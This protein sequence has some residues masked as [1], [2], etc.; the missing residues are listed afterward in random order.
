M[1]H[2]PLPQTNWPQAPRTN[3][4]PRPLESEALAL[5]R[6]FLTPLLERAN[7]W[8]DLSHK[9][10]DKG[11]ALTFRLGHLVVLNDN[12]EALCTGTD[13]GIPLADLSRRIG[14]PCVRANR[15]GQ[16]GD[17]ALKEERRPA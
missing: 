7:S 17:L 3:G 13:L 6:L 16:A 1:F 2:A 14:R 4:L 8:S 10:A 9:L 12:G 11:F 15:T 5:L